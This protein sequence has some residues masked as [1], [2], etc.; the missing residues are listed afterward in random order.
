MTGT[1]PGLGHCV[2]SLCLTERP[3]G[4]EELEGR[5]LGRLWEYIVSFLMLMW[6]AGSQ[7]CT[8]ESGTQMC[9][10]VAGEWT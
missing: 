9:G 8:G 5:L 7:D 3:M 2:D 10:T 6:F 4:P 1:Y